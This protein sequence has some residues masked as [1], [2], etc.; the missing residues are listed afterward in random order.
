MARKLIQTFFGEVKVGDYIVE[1]GEYNW[2]VQKIRYN[3]DR[4]KVELTVYRSPTQIR[5]AVGGFGREVVVKRLENGQS[6]STKPA[7]GGHNR[8]TPLGQTNSGVSHRS[9]RTRDLRIPRR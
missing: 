2:L 1:D 4:T 3:D 5:T 8:T 7:S 9:K 6:T